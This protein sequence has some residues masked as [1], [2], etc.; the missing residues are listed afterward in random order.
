MSTLF[1]AI[2]YCIPLLLQY[3]YIYNSLYAKK[4]IKKKNIKALTSWLAD[5]ADFNGD[6]DNDDG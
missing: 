2:L 6:D 4:L 3:N 1:Q 5:L